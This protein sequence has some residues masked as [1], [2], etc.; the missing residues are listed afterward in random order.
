MLVDRLPV[1]MQ[2]RIRAERV[3][4]K[5]W[6]EIARESSTWKEWEKVP[7]GVRRLFAVSSIQVRTPS[8]CFRRKDNS[9]R[10]NAVNGKDGSPS[11]GSGQA[12][13]GAVREG[14]TTYRIP[15]SNLRRWYDLRVEQVLREQQERFAAAHAI[16]DRCAASGFQ[17]LTASVKHA[18]GEFVFAVLEAGK[19][20][21][22][23]TAALT[24]LGHL[25][26]KF[27]RNDLKREEV[28]QEK[29]KIQL[30]A[31]KLDLMR[32]NVKGLKEAVAK[33]EVTPEQLQQKLDEIY[34]LGA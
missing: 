32:G 3:G 24:D 12:L 18:L 22:K 33:K 29:Q 5:T 34:G 9:K 31:R 14:A 25:L 30:L 10:D 23:I 6:R 15:L 27:D 28:R 11:Q 1:E 26:A 19:D 8:T 17:N 7:E 4:G 2:D 16:A 21:D 20:S 13:S